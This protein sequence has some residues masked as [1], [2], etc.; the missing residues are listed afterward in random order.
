M[1]RSEGLDPATIAAHGVR[2]PAPETLP[3][4]ERAVPSTE[5][6]YLT[7]VMDF[8]S[9]EGSERP[10]LGQ[11]GYVYAR[12][13]M[14]NGRSLELT[15]AA[16]EGG[17]DGLATASGMAAVACSLLALA[18]AGDRIVLQRDAYG[19][20]AALLSQD[21]AR[22]G[23]S[24]DTFDAY[25]P[26]AVA[27]ALE[28]P[29]KAVIVESIS[30][31][32]VREADVVAIAA[33]CRARGVPLIVDATF[34]TPIVARPLAQGA[35]VVVHSA[36]K[37][38]GGHHD[39]CAGLV[40]GSKGLVAEARGI[41]R[42]FGA[43]VSPM[44]AWLAT[45]GMKTLGVRMERACQTAGELAARLGGHGKVRRVNYPG[46]GALLS[47]DVDDG[48]AAARVVRALDLITLTPSLGG[49]A[50]SLSHA[51]SSSHRSLDAE[52]RR[53]MGIGDGLLRLS[54]GLE[55]VVD[56]WRDLDRALGHA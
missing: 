18:R 19:G 13:G 35:D 40:V 26:S 4:G 10:L 20:T 14:P 28:R 11:G 45:R 48:A 34:A 43:I 53:H 44:D 46:K 21:F 49:T 54:A 25:D 9:I 3:V 52:V 56:L 41:A 22:F 24:V 15:A 27:R 55:A 30:N 36:T 50:T 8:D 23:I 32:L 5:P 29:V 6:L 17:E 12:H 2:A 39:L 1:K 37:Y 42:R 16:L 33:A 31:P 38:L 7:S 51:A 47:F